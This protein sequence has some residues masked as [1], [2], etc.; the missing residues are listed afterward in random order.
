MGYAAVMHP[1]SNFGQAE[2]FVNQEFFD[3]VDFLG[4]DVLFYRCACDFRKKITQVNIAVI[5]F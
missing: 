3:P 1:E 4:D 5:H 2:I